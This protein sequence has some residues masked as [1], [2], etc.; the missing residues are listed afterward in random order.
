MHL[1]KTIQYIKQLKESNMNQIIEENDEDKD[2]HSAF[3]YYSVK[4]QDW[5]H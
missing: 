4:G 3:E 5:N 1:A 2:D